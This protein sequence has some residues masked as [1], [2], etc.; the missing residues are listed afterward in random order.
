MAGRFLAAQS[1]P[2]AETVLMLNGDEEE[3]DRVATAKAILQASYGP[4]PAG[5]LEGV[6]ASNTLMENPPEDEG[7]IYTPLAG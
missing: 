4:T 7:N 5:F 3:L 2:S 6:Q 1:S